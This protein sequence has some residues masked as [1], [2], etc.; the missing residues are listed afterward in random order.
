MEKTH[1]LDKL[2][3]SMSYNTVD[4]EFNINESIIYIE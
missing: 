4:Y 1:V 3:S 2:H